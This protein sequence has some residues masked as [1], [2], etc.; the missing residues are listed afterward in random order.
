MMPVR[1]ASCASWTSCLTGEN[2]MMQS[3]RYLVWGE[4][5]IGIMVYRILLRYWEWTTEQEDVRPL[6]FLMRE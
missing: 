3:L 6:I 2:Q 1:G 4:G 5:E